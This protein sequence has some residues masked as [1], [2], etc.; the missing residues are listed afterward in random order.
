MRVAIYPG[1]FDPVTNGHLDIIKRASTMFD[2][3]IV[4]VLNN[5]SKTPLFSVEER[6]KMLAEVTKDITNVEVDSFSGLLIDYAKEKDVHIAIRGLRAMTDF[7][8]ELHLAQTNF[9]I[10]KGELETVFLT[11]D[12]AYSY[13]AS[14]TVRE[15][16][17]F[18][19]DISACVPPYIAEKL[20]EKCGYEQIK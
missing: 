5:S 15:I 13:L 18:H 3:I 14:S 20:Y 7:D 2:K 11:T 12:L 8:Y 10:S 16:A 9:L 19:G 6:V 17:S 1:S 4:S